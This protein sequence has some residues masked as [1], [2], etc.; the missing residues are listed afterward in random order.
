MNVMISRAASILILFSSLTPTM[1]QHQ[2]YAGMQA[3]S[4]KALS[5]QQFADLKASRGMGLALAAEL[6]GYPGPI[7]VIEL[8]KDLALTTE[9]HKQ[10]ENLV[11]AMKAETIPLGEQLIGLETDLD[12]LFASRTIT[13]DLLKTTMGNIGAVQG[14]LRA[15]HLK[16]HLLTLDVLTPQQVA[17]YSELRGYTQ[18]GHAH[19]H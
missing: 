17:R 10:V 8:S 6:N 12:H 5:E 7:H 13:Q 1:A 15:G 11:T 2:P 3:R 9:Q 14:S 16:Y 19:P 18:P 4:V